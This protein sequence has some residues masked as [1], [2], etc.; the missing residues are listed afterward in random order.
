MT[1]G[2]TPP[3]GS[4]GSATYVMNAETSTQKRMEA[5]MGPPRDT[6]PAAVVRP[7]DAEA[8]GCARWL[9]VVCI[10]LLALA[11]VMLLV[12][13][14]VQPGRTLA[15]L[16]GAPVV[17][18]PVATPASPGEVAGALA[19]NLA[20]N[21]PGNLGGNLAENIAALPTYVA[22]LPGF[23]LWVSDDFSAPSALAPPQAIPGQ[24][25]AAVVTDAGV[26][27]LQVEPNQIGWTLFDLAGGG[28]YR[29]ETSAAISSASPGAS[30]GVIGRFNGAGSFYLLTVDGAGTAKLEQ[31]VGGQPTTVQTAI[32]AINRA[33][34]ANQ[35]AVE[36]DGTRLH[37]YVNGALMTEVAAPV[38]PLGRPGIAAVV[39]GPDPGTVDFDWI[40]IYRPE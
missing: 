22:Q 18:T 32:G 39:P 4:Q 13:N 8:G 6:A 37:F 10:A 31:W 5:N 14:V 1:A 26:Y 23:Q 15:G 38:L 24:V 9:L 12:A 36:D 30:A 3:S 11:L 20:E 2:N 25:N 40:A 35:L 27:R 21:L 34:S 17:S 33:G 19:D 7:P 29:L 16:F 28:P